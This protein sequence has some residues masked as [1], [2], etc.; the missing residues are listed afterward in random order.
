MGRYITEEILYGGK[1][2]SPE[3]IKSMA[4]TLLAAGQNEAVKDIAA[5]IID[6]AFDKHDDE[7][8]K[9]G[10]E[11]MVAATPTC[12]FPADNNAPKANDDNNRPTES[13]IPQIPTEPI[14]EWDNSFDDVFHTNVKPQEIKK[15]LEILT[16]ATLSEDKR[17]FVYYKILVYIR[18]I[19]TEKRG[20]KKKF[21]KWW[22]LHFKCN[23]SETDTLDPFKFRVDKRLMDSQ[24]YNWNKIEIDNAS[25]YFEFAKMVKNIFTQTVVNNLAT[26]GQDFNVGPLL[27][28]RQFLK[29]PQQP[30]NNGKVLFTA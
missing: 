13:A 3:E 23:W 12:S 16:S 17:R 27:D 7:L 15:A 2:H 28:R 18:W 6:A 22:N 1:S 4:Y 8:R 26:D 11:L 30:I 10:R 21:L 24:P 9:I 20:S 5:H 25:S 29:N 19:S 14:E